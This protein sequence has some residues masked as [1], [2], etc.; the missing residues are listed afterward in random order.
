MTTS[1]EPVPPEETPVSTEAASPDAATA[2][3]ASTVQHAPRRG[4]RAVSTLLLVAAF[5][6]VGGIGFAAGRMTATGQ[7]GA[8]SQYG[9]M[10]GQFRPGMGDMG[11]LASGLPDDLNRMGMNA[12]VSGTVVSIS[13]SEITLK[14]ANGNKVTIAIGSS[15]TYHTQS[16]ASSSD[17]TAGDTVQVSVTGAGANSAGTQTA[18]DIVI[19]QP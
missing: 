6:A 17:V 5:A 3:G 12:T 16:V 1:N 9:N 15:T 2:E 19:T 13:S 10:D 4:S 14:L 18:S 7:T 8:N 11:P